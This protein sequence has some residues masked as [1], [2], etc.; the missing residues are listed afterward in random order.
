[1]VQRSS[2]PCLIEYLFNEDNEG[3]HY[4]KHIIGNNPFTCSHAV[5]VKNHFFHSTMVEFLDSLQN[6]SIPTLA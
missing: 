1:M 5:A 6:K 2:Y 3:W 4:I